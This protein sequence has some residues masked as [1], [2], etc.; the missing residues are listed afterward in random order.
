VSAVRFLGEPQL[1]AAAILLKTIFRSFDLPRPWEE[2]RHG[3][4][5]CIHD[6]TKTCAFWRPWKAEGKAAL[7]QNQSNHVAVSSGFY[8]AT[9]PWGIMQW[10]SATRFPWCRILYDG[11]SLRKIAC[12][13]RGPRFFPWLSCIVRLWPSLSTSTRP[14][15]T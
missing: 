2:V 6:A 15:I 13:F 9:L 3:M 8:R 14:P 7:S 10:C 5:G 4:S 11:K 12:L 1:R